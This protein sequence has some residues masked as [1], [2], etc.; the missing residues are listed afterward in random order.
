MSPLSPS[1][2]SEPAR[3]RALSLTSH[4]S[5]RLI[6][7]SH[8]S[9]NNA[10]NGSATGDIINSSHSFRGRSD[11]QSTGRREP[12]RSFIA[13]HQRHLGS[14]DSAEI[15][16]S[17]R[18]DTAGLA[19]YA[20]SERPSNRSPSPTS[21]QRVASGQ[22]NQGV[23]F[24]DFASTRESSE[25]QREHQ[26]IE[27]ISEPNSSEA[28]SSKSSP[29]T[30]ALADLLRR[31]PPST[32]PLDGHEEQD[33][34]GK[35]D[36]GNTMLSDSDRLIITS[37]GVRRDATERTPLLSKRHEEQT[38]PDWIHG[39]QDLEGQYLRRQESWPKLKNIVAK[40]LQKGK[41]VI[42]TL[43]HP[44][45]WDRRAIWNNAVVA[46][47]AA[48]PAVILGLLLNIL[49]AL[50]YGLILFPL[51]EKVF[52]DLGPSGISMFYISCI[53]SQLVYSCGGSIFKG[54]IGSEMIEVVPFFHGMAATILTTVGSDKPQEVISTTITAYAISS[55]FTGFAFLLMGLFRVGYIIGFIPRHILIGCIGGVGWFLVATGLEVSARLPGSLNYDLETLLRL[56]QLDT[57]PLW[58]VPMLL[59]I[60]IHFTDCRIP[61]KY[62]KYY[63]PGMI[64]GVGAI[65]YFFVFALDPLSLPFLKAHGWVFDGPKN[66]NEPWWHFYTL[67]DFNKVHWGA[68]AETIPAMFALTFFGVLHVPINVPALANTTQ[69]DNVN[70]DH[71]LIAHGFSNMISGFV[72]SIQNYLVYTNSVVFMKSGGNS[73]LAG[74]MLAF[75]TF[76]V[77][78]IGPSIIGLI[79]VMTVG[80]LIFVLGFD[81]LYEALVEPRHK[82]KLSEYLT[83]VTIVLI[84]GLYDFV[85]GI[86]IGLG[87]AGVSLVVQASRT[88]A[89]RAS[90]SGE[91]AGSTVRRNPTQYRYL[92]EVG[93]QVHVTKL[94]GYLFFGTIVSVEARIRALITDEAF[95]ERPVRFLIFDLYHVSGIDYSAG[96]SFCKLNRLCSK[97][98]V[99]LIMSGLDANGPLGR[100]LRAVGLGEVTEDSAEV[101]FFPDLNSALESC[102]N[103]LLKTF[104]ASKERATSRNAP[105]D[106][107]N[108]QQK[109]INN[110]TVS[111]DVQFSSPRRQH[112]HRAATATLAE[113]PS[114]SRYMNFKE[115]LKLI[116]QTFHDVTS[117]NEDF[118]F[119]VVP[120]F[121]RQEYPAGAI[122]YQRGE[123][124]N[125]FYLLES[126]ILRA[127]Y[128]LPQGQYFESIVAGTT[129]GELPFFSETGRSATVVAE[130]DSVVW[131]M[132]RNNW[133]QLQK[134]DQEVASELLKIS[135]KLTSERFSA[136]TSYVLTTAG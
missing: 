59:A 14:I 124:A 46:P 111:I 53:V 27:E 56:F 24:E 73:R 94:A 118:W 52:E 22:S 83:V 54:G 79:P 74:I 114:E 132:D 122:L 20:L 69:E 28:S 12:T 16:R 38:H 13:A 7:G 31:S 128:E 113:G 61:E 99:S 29:S 48:L 100:S 101:K 43:Q 64:L 80:I 67:Y 90:Y 105:I 133:D 51:G 41:Y 109:H 65:F 119:R 57:F 87:L 55:I 60:F 26:T 98:G 45:M 121:T 30:S 82:L 86:F 63:L 95:K 131:L 11:S 71:E 36:T 32:S 117:Q 10:T 6:P 34:G 23:H 96:E 1:P 92:R 66:V 77:M 129:C 5:P 123:S 112:L 47:T 39:Q 126:G 44:K 88:A 125:G 104:Y 106:V 8:G 127:D 21:R 42:T 78:L 58:I 18:E 97:K 84:M 93:Q 85:V 102:E 108:H 25:A 135:L 49:D 91:V 107:P 35:L 75:A 103:E 4:T 115:P 72:G 2:S 134:T 40:P 37:D 33:D 81:L 89:V 68:L 15:A 19:S 50:S 110:G 136:I 62:H 116:L 70:L 17:V 76:G 130:R 9:M 3:R 120:F